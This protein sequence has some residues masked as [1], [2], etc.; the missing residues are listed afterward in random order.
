MEKRVW[1]N[2]RQPQTLYIAQLLMYFQGGFSLL[3]ALLGARSFG[4]YTLTI[5]VGKLMAAFGIANERRWGYRLGVVVAVIP[6][7]LLLLL[8][9]T[10]TPRWLWADGIGLLFDIALIALLLYPTSRDYQRYWPKQ[11][12]RPRRG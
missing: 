4:I 3:F 7:A 11:Q 1:V 9:V 10:D 8:A 12:R 2:P 5:A 6:V